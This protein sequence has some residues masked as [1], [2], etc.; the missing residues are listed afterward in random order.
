MALKKLYES[1]TYE[2]YQ[3][4]TLTF[5]G[6]P[7]IRLGLKRRGFLITYETIKLPAPGQMNQFNAKVNKVLRDFK[8]I[9]SNEENREGQRHQMVTASVDDAVKRLFGPGP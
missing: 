5:F 6:A 4:D 8:N 1:G 3:V 2:I 9:I 7:A